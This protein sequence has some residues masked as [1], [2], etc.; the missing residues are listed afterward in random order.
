MSKKFISILL[1]VMMVLSV[2]SGFGTIVRAEERNEY[3]INVDVE[4]LAPGFEKAYTG[5]NYDLALKLSDE[6]LDKFEEVLKTELPNVEVFDRIELLI[7]ALVAK[8]NAEE[9]E[10][11]K[12]LPNVLEV[13][14]NYIINESDIV[15]SN[16]AVFQ[17][18][19]GLD[20]SISMVN[21]NDLIGNDDI[22]QQ[23]Y[24]GRGRVLAIIDS[25]MDPTHSAFYLSPGVRPRLAKL[26]INN[27][28]NGGKLSIKDKSAEKK[29]YEDIYRS[30]KI[31]FGW[32][33]NTNNKDLNPEKEEAAHGQHVSGTVAGNKFNID[34]KTWRGVA[35]EAQLLMMN[36][37][38]K[39]STSSNIYIRAMQDAIVM[40]AD[41]V[42]MSLGS[43]KA[44][45][46]QADGLVGKAINSGY[47]A[48]T[49]FIIA[50]GNEGEY[51]GNL[52]I[53]N[54]DFGTIASPGI[55]TNAI[56]VAS[57]ENKNM[58]AQ[59]LD[60]EEHKYAFRKAGT[61]F[62]EKGDYEFVDCGIGDPKDFEGKGVE[63]K[64]ALIKRG[65]GITF[66]NKIK[67]A[68]A[69]K[70]I[71]VMIYNNVE[72]EL[73]LAIEGTK[74]PAVALTLEVGEKLL[75]GKSNV[76]HIDM[77][78]REVPNPEYGELSSF[79]NW[80]L[81]A[82]GYMKPDITAPGGHIYSTQTMGDTF[83]DMSGTSMATPHVTGGVGII[84]DRLD[85]MMFAGE[86]HKAALT[87]TILMNSAIP[88]LDPKTNVTT[89][90]RRQGAGV[91]NLKKATELDFTAV[92]KDTKIASK[93]VGNVDDTI[94]LNLLV[95]NYSGEM[96]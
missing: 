14:E 47:A 54:P 33:Y 3:I 74:I 17:D 40:G 71:G 68:E 93:F 94:T 20:E 18:R 48:D 53:E 66:T 9:L 39:G 61:I 79:T 86:V 38:K 30:E 26:D 62:F 77:T 52:N 2:F 81:A 69:A 31:P 58:F 85:D 90:P 83:G 19:G 65:G 43:T 95:H 28:L 96:K 23:K 75:N 4:K 44:L 10:R 21:S 59:V 12:N 6:A 46:G 88:H 5:Q 36:V 55:A 15:R 73:G 57:L 35:P 80:G 92:D 22:F 25:N 87:K 63:G 70:A 7:P 89:S 13:F 84:R 32:N 82:G 56:T 91:M 27:F 60:Y 16:M 78:P 72:G 24:D 1:S 45:P 67:N 51:Q 64:V 11:A 34:G 49:N 76:V 37:M 41:A 42:N 29:L 8:M 50:A